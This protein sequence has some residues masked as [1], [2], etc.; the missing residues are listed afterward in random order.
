MHYEVTADKQQFSGE[1]EEVEGGDAPP[2]RGPRTETPSVCGLVKTIVK[3]S[4]TEPEV[5][6]NEEVLDISLC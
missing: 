6:V 2:P 1:E 5:N 4:Q 3:I